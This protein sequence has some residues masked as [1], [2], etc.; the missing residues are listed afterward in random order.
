MESVFV[1]STFRAQ[2]KATC[3]SGATGVP[4]IVLPLGTLANRNTGVNGG[5]SQFKTFFIQLST[6]MTREVYAHV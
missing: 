3:I 4:F 5:Q 1:H 6:Y 2:C